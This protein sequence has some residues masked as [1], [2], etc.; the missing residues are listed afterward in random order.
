MLQHLAQLIEIRES[1]KT[2]LVR[3]SSNGEIF[4]VPQH[5]VSCEFSMA[6]PS[7]R[8]SDNEDMT[9][10]KY[11]GK[12]KRVEAGA[13]SNQQQKH[14]GK[15]RSAASPIATAAVATSPSLECPL[16]SKDR[17]EIQHENEGLRYKK[18]VPTFKREQKERDQ[19]AP[20]VLGIMRTEH[21][22]PAVKFVPGSHQRKAEG[23]S[24][25][26][27]IR[28]E[29]ESREKVLQEA[30]RQA[31][32]RARRISKQEHYSEQGKGMPP[33]HIYQNVPFC[34]KK[35]T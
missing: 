33:P 19:R 7:T 3:L 34:D 29:I 22:D 23:Q 20:S 18:S 31:G 5:A 4:R 35:L 30:R 10:L 26:D 32:K 28:Q 25:L 14:V 15:G 2:C 11:V 12:R 17:V 24:W 6:T 16:E 8:S 27:Y 1:D 9:R 13:T 21:D